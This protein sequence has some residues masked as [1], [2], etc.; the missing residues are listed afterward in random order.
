[1]HMAPLSGIKATVRTTVTIAN[2]GRFSFDVWLAIDGK[3][4]HCVEAAGFEGERPNPK[5]G[6]KIE[7]H[8]KIHGDDIFATKIDPVTD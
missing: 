8:G 3:L 5:V 2:N 4:V 7:I 6:D 1:M